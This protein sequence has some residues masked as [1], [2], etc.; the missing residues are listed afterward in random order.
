MTNRTPTSKLASFHA[1]PSVTSLAGCRYA[2]GILFVWLI[3]LLV[4]W[5]NTGRAITFTNFPAAVSNT[6]N[7]VITL[8]IN[9]L[10]T[11][12]ASVVVQKYLDLNTNGIIDSGDLLVQQFQLIE[13]Q[14]PTFTNGS[15]LVTVTNFMPGDMLTSTTGQITAP[16]NFQDGDFMQNLAGQYFYKI[17]S[18]S[19]QFSPLTNIFTV[20][21]M[22]F[23]SAVTGLV[24][25]TAT[26][27][28]VSNSVVL[29]FSTQNGGAYVQAGAVANSSG[30]FSISAPVGSYF[31][32]AAKTNFTASFSRSFALIAGG[33]NDQN[34]ALTPATTNMVGRL[35]NVVAGSTIPGVSGLAISTNANLSLF[36]SD[37]N[38]NFVV[39]VTNS[40]WEAE[41][42]GFSVAFAGYLTPQTN[43]L[44]SVSNS[45]VTITNALVPVTGILSGIVTNNTGSPMPGVYLYGF[46]NANHQSWALTD[47]NGNYVLG[48]GTNLWQMAILSPNNPGLT[49]DFVFSPGYVQAAFTNGQAI[50]QNFGLN[51]APYTINGT[52]K[53]EAGTAIGGVQVF[54]TG[55]NAFGVSYQAFTATTAADG[56]YSMSISPGFWTVGL[57]SNSLIA[58]N[59][60]YTNTPAAQSTNL[61][62]GGSAT[63]NFSILVCGEVGILT[64]NLPNAMVGSFYDTTLLASACQ[65]ITNWS[66][67]Y[68]VT[69]TGLS[70]QTNVTYPAGTAIYSDSQLVGYIETYFSFGMYANASTYSSNISCN[71]SQKNTQTWAFKNLS[72]S[73]N[74][75]G[76]ITNVMGIQF[77]T[78][79]GN[80]WT[81]GPTTNNGSTY[82][83]AVTLG[84]YDITWNNKF[85]P[86]TINPGVLMVGSGSPSNTV[87][88]LPGNFTSL[89]AGSS[90]NTASPL[91]YNGTGSSVVWIQYGANL[92]QYL[93]TA[94]GPQSTNLPPG[95]YFTNYQ[96]DTV[97]LAGTPTGIGTNNG[98]FNFT[99]EAQDVLSN[100]AI[101]PLSILVYPTQ[102]PTNS[103][104]PSA[105]HGTFNLQVNG[106]VPGLNY[107]V[108]MSTNLPSTNWIP[109]FTTNTPNINSFT[110]PDSNATNKE[111]F[112]RIE[113]GP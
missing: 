72:A 82:S 32:A 58:V 23:S 7:G 77:Q 42:N 79:P 55:T 83:T 96:G 27:T 98:I 59:S 78:L 43:Q 90:V 106:V 75:S 71:I 45:L 104:A 10:P 109:I 99:V 13:G 40:V 3:V 105:S 1:A 12:P 65:G 9:G 60:Q 107:T 19:G 28:V 63:I 57:N 113:V 86:Y 18:P 66:T 94:F 73:V 33:T 88:T 61:L 54:A 89:P 67:A 47:K 49:N 70:D 46:D 14:A 17:S 41:L 15:T 76:P 100:T 108:L 56:S 97:E 4:L 112:Y 91:P 2:P 53:T 25:N 80:T 29:L 81:V 64:T 51:L 16:L 111:R 101:Q 30:F 68:G 37:T 36:I 74:V 20:T 31:L 6:Y 62:T 8:Q 92:G 5:A 21:N 39:P 38:G 22:P 110:F 26:S 34:T 24:I 87:A 102:Q 95:L 44:F 50:R 48:V 69:I 52:V 103:A 93:I 85:Q 35:T 84:E 11:G